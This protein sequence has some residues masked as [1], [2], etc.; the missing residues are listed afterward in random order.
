MLINRTQARCETCFWWRNEDHN[1]ETC[2]GTYNT[3]PGHSCPQYTA[4]KS[5]A[6]CGECRWLHEPMRNRTCYN[7]YGR[8]ETDP[9][10]D[11]PLS[12]KRKY[13][14]HP[15]TTQVSVSNPYLRDEVTGNPLDVIDCDPEKAS[16][17][18][19]P[20]DGAKYGILVAVQEDGAR[21]QPVEIVNGEITTTGSRRR[22]EQMAFAGEVFAVD[23]GGDPHLIAGE[24]QNLTIRFED[25]DKVWRQARADQAKVK[26]KSDSLI[27]DLIQI[28]EP[29]G[30]AE[31]PAEK[32][33]V[34]GPAI[35]TARNVALAGKVRDPVEIARRVARRFSSS[36]EL[37]ESERDQLQKKLLATLLERK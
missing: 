3:A 28:D 26:R 24:I 2:R 31:W 22:F 5:M 34:L 12:R 4:D 20:H 16:V 7:D 29:K 18:L 35:T 6:R 13:T 15:A 17:L 9:F 11:P 25:P 14:R 36:H 33:Y 30:I 1:G 37:T 8:K 27:S 21:V 23:W 32:A 10:C 19:I